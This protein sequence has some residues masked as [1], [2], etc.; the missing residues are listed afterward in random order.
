MKFKLRLIMIITK[1]KTFKI[2]NKDKYKLQRK[3]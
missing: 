3:N 2:T 1:N